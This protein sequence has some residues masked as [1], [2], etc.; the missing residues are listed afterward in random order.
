MTVLSNEVDERKSV[1]LATVVDETA[2]EFPRVYVAPRIC[3]APDPYA[4]ADIVCEPSST[5][6]RSYDIQV[7]ATLEGSGNHVLD[8]CR[9]VILP[10]KYELDGEALRSTEGDQFASSLLR[11]KVGSL[12]IQKQAL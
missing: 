6:W 7:A 1:F 8:T 10:D 5:G 2:K 9:V 12:S 4:D 11:H 3:N